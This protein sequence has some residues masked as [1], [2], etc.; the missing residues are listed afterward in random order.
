MSETF[1]ETVESEALDAP[2]AERAVLACVL[3][4]E[5]GSHAALARV[6]PILPRDGFAVSRNAT[7]WAAILA[8]RDRGDGVDVATVRDELDAQGMRDA[9]RYLG[10]ILRAPI[11]PRRC[12]VYAR[13]VA[14]WSLLRATRAGLVKA[15]DTARGSGDP[16]AVVSAARAALAALP[17]GIATQRD[18]S[19]GAHIGAAL[20]EIGRAAEDAANGVSRA[21]RWGIAALDGGQKYDGT[22]R[23]GALGGLFPGELHVVGGPPAGGKTTLAWC[24]VIATARAQRPVH[25]FSLE[26]SGKVLAKRLIGQMAG[27]PQERLKA[28][29]LFDG[30]PDLLRRAA[31]EYAKLPIYVY[32]DCDTLDAI[33]SRVRAEK[34]RGDVALVVIDY[35]QLLQH[36]GT[37][38]DEN[39]ADAQRVQNLKRFAVSADVPVL[40]LSAVTKAAQRNMKETK[41]ADASDVKGSGSEFAANAIFY[42]VRDDYEAPGPR[43]SVTLVFAKNR[44]GACRPVPVIWDMAR[45][46]F[47]SVEGVGDR[48]E[49]REREAAEHDLIN[50]DG[51]DA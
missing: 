32:D 17:E 36:A 28:G 34:A 11:T 39:R 42:V 29:V 19:L 25:V 38:R 9:G 15:L 23:P 31:Q 6:E 8:C 4:D 50:A 14:E 24:A 45:G 20:E 16:L 30:E 3:L 47:E 10:D 43:V 26:M 5:D 21:A 41:Q 37:V 27:I 22:H 35:L 46:V 13:R 1:Y 44:D 33:M 40:A 48:E 2:N 51:G 18:Y 49:R 12:E 7:V